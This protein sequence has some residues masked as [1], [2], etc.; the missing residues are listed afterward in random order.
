LAA[1]V[2]ILVWRVDLL[3][4]PGYRLLM[5]RDRVD[6]FGA[7]LTAAGIVAAGSDAF[8]PLRIE[9]GLP[10]VGVDLSD[11]NFAQEAMRTAK[12]ISFKKGCYLGQEPIARIDALG[13]INRQ[14]AGV[15]LAAGPGPSGGANVTTSDAKEAGLLT[16]VA[17]SP[18]SGQSVALAI[19]K[20]QTAAVGTELQVATPQ[21]MI[22][23]TVFAW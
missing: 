18:G 17:F 11:E 19:L 13:H 14:L 6:E 9:A 15:R 23:G 16:S 3:R 7:A 12:A 22:S 1:P 5:P 21:G 2:E 20:S 10:L 4:V 8:E